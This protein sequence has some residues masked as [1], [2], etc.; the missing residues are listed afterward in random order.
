MISSG[1]FPN[2]STFLTSFINK[3]A[4]R[5]ISLTDIDNRRLWSFPP[6]GEI[7]IKRATREIMIK[8]HRIK[9]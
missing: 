9:L 3:M 5:P 7:L 4:G 8:L 1:T 2:S 6:T